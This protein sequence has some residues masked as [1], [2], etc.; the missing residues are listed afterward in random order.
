V[1]RDCVGL[2]GR[3]LLSVAFDASV[4]AIL[5]GDERS[6]EFALAVSNTNLLSEDQSLSQKVVSYVF[7]QTHIPG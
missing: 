2:T 7:G 3:V 5:S 6:D 4:L 1:N